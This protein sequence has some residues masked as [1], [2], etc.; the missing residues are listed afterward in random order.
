MSLLPREIARERA[1][2]LG[3]I[4]GLLEGLLEELR[5]L[6]EEAGTVP[7][8]KLPALR[9]WYAATREKAQLY[10]WYLIVQREA[11]G[12]FDVAEVDRRFPPPPPLE[13]MSERD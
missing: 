10:R 2:A 6:R 9:R 12:L 7:R 3:R 13:L 11:N 8:E 4:G 5:R 1:E